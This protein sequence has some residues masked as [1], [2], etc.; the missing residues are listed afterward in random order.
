MVSELVVFDIRTSSETVVL[1]TD[2]HI[3]APN[4]MPDDSALIVNADGALFRVP[5][6]A[7][8]LNQIETAGLNKLNNDHGVSP[9]GRFFALSDK[10]ETGECHIY[11]MPV[12]GG[13][14]RRVTDAGFSYW[15][16]WSPDGRTLAYA[17]RRDGA[18]DI[19]VKPVDG[20]PET[21]LTSGFDHCDGP[22]YS[23]DGKWIWFNGERDGSV[24]LWRVPAV[25]G[26][27]VQMTDDDRVNWFP[28][29]S[30]DGRFVLYLAYK[31]GTKGHPANADV[32][33]RML[34]QSGGP[35]KKL[36]TLFGGQGTINVP[37]WAPDGQ[38]FAFVRYSGA[39]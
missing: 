36:T 5:F 12:T 1:K 11:I 13:K 17:G 31:P 22:D 33:L 19:Y 15:H 38:R 7:P 35:S 32:T 25:G 26:T 29:P 23:P 4:W 14:P 37:C 8:V 16:G 30:P 28:H 20:G 9:D 34:P 10:S 21:R 2:T 3:E 24:D 39:F 27:P 18:F 6:A